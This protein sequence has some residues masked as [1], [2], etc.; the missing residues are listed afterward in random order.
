MGEISKALK[1][2]RDALASDSD[3]SPVGPEGSTELAHLRAREAAEAAASQP[4]RSPKTPPPSSTPPTPHTPPAPLADT[5]VSDA[6]RKT[7]KSMPD[8]PSSERFHS[9]LAD[10]PETSDARAVITNPTGVMATR[11]R[12]LAVRVRRELDLRTPGT[13]L[14]TSAVSGEGKTLISVN[15]A[16]ALAAI[17]TE[18]RVALVDLD[19]YRSRFCEAIGYR[20]TVGVEAILSKEGRTLEDIVVRTDVGGLDIYPIANMQ[21]SGHDLLGGDQAQSMLRTLGDRYDY[22][23]IDGPPV[24]PVPDVPLVASYVGGVLAIARSGSTRR[25]LFREMVSLLPSRAL[26]GTILN[27]TASARIG[28]AYGYGYGYGYWN[29]RGTS[30]DEIDELNQEG[31]S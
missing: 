2:A 16:I 23:I 15:L 12:H 17:E 18:C 13:L 19:F 3:A 30:S 29:K 10:R 4:A 1:R 8:E 9:L 22:V 25:R 31:S 6:M 24:L 21:M 28:G 7:A 26:I 11:L 20:A 14:I 27:D 5:T